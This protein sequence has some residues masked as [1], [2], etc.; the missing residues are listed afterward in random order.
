ME[1]VLIKDVEKLGKRGDVIQ[2]R[3]GYGRN[4]LIPSSLALPATRQNRSLIEVEKKRAAERR[5]REQN[6]AQ[7][8]SQKVS[9]LKIRIEAEAGEKDKL[10]GSVTS[11][12]I[13]EALQKEGIK[14][15]RKQVRLS[16]PIHALGLHSVTVELAPEVKVSF[17]V[18]IVKK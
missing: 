13:A 14:I 18:E 5:K 3:N 7:E 1:I 17:S 8:L 6:S 12:D 4:Y 2:V 10:F 9:K 11:Q 16:E 15:D